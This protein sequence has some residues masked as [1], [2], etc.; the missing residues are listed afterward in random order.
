MKGVPSSSSAS[1]SCCYYHCPSKKELTSSFVQML[2][3]FYS[4]RLVEDFHHR[5]RLLFPVPHR[6]F[7]QP[8]PPPVQLN[9]H[10]ANHSL[11]STEFRK[12]QTGPDSTGNR[13][14]RAHD[15]DASAK[16]R[17]QHDIDLEDCCRR[18]FHL[19]FRLRFHCYYCSDYYYRFPLHDFFSRVNSMMM[20]LWEQNSEN[21]L[22]KEC[23]S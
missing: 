21:D 22:S 13:P 12:S 17:L 10:S 3:L 23:L 18:H 20:T 5:R 16:Q 14:S 9:M 19:H 8:Y 2:M 4:Q 1:S 11:R 15:L 6:H 7:Q